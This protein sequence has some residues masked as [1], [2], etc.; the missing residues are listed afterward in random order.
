MDLLKR[1]IIYSAVSIF[2]LSYLDAMLE[3]SKRVD[4]SIIGVI[5]TIPVW[6]MYIWP[7]CFS[8]RNGHKH[9]I[10]IAVSICNLVWLTIYLMYVLAGTSY[11]GEHGELA[12]QL[13]IVFLPGL[14]FVFTF[15]ILF[16][17]TIVLIVVK[18]FTKPLKRPQTT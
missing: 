5:A 12:T 13:H 2:A 14:F 6:I 1:I 7:T 16:I 18:R 8:K 17:A 15:S 9:L 11:Q 10:L 3:L 4:S